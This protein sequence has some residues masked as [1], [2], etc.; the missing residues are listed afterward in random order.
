VLNQTIATMILMI[1]D[2]SSGAREQEMTYAQNAY[3]QALAHPIFFKTRLT[4]A[5]P[6]PPPPPPV[7]RPAPPPAPA[8]DPGLAVGGVVINGEVKNA[9]VFRKADHSGSW[10]AE[11]EEIMGWKVHSIDNGGAK[12]RKDDRNIELQLYT[13][14]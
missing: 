10:L 13:Q 2:L 3:Q 7:S 4:F 11:G 14:Q 9:Y 1:P 12:L 6:P 8:A 5:P